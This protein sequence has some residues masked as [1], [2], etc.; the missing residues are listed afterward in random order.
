M[1]IFTKS[2]LR[3]AVAFLIIAFLIPFRSTL[4]SLLH[5]DISLFLLLAVPLLYAAWGTANRQAKAAKL[6]AANRELER[7]VADRKRAEAGLKETLSLLHATLE[8]TTDGILVVDRQGKITGSNRK[9]AEMWQLPPSVVA[10]GED[11]RALASVLDQLI[12]PEHFF[13]KVKKLYDQPNAESHDLL[14]FKDGRVFERHSKP[15]KIEDL[16][17]GRV[18]TFR[19]I[20]EQRRNQQALQEQAIRDALTG[21]YNRRY[22]DQRAEDEIARADREKQP[23]AILMCD[24]DRFKVLNDT[25]G[26]QVGDMVLKGVAASILDSTRGIDLIFR[27]GG[28]EIVV[29]L[30]KT[31]REGVQT[32]ANRIRDGVVRTGKEA[33]IPLDI[34]IGAALYPEHGTKIDELIS[35]ADRSLY[36]AKKGGDKIHIGDQEYTLDE[37]VVRIV[38]Q[39]IFDL[40]SRQV[41]GH[42][43]LSR[44]PKGTLTITQLFKKYQA[45]GQLGELKRICFLSQLK[46]AERIGLPRIF[47]NVDFDLLEQLGPLPKPPECDLILEISESE[48]LHNIEQHLRITRKWKEQGFRFAMDDFGAGFISLPFLSQLLPD[49][50]KIDRSAI[51]Q[52]VESKLFRQ[53]LA[54]LIATLGHYETTKII[55]EGIETED[56]LRIVEEMG[57]SLVQ[58]FLFGKQEEWERGDRIK[59]TRS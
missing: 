20:T 11:D 33:G 53:F 22:F 27:W 43:A 59:I 49:Y 25:L 46:A 24:L 44:D 40:I 2:V 31:N 34:S 41:I 23:L 14:E 30:S 52:A 54:D 51:L 57:I 17:V 8:S 12:D 28:D 16:S 38:F 58:G 15:Q 7:E 35:M 19:D 3:Y 9:F 36:I 4:L 1:I 29:I 6:E 26:H 42:E 55:A 47:I 45:I 48:A 32:A 13:A 10:S 18:W 37:S 50:I 56:E 21:L 39:P 5:Y